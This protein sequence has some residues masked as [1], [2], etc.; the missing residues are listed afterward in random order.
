MPNGIWLAIPGIPLVTAGLIGI[1]QILGVTRTEEGER[2]VRWL[3]LGALVGS[4][5]LVLIAVA[6]YLAHGVPQS[7]VVANWLQS[8]QYVSTLSFSIDGLSLTFATL[9][10]VISLLVMRFAVNYLHR[11]AGF[12]RFFMVLC[13]FTTALQIIALSGSAVLS[14]VGWELAGISSYLLIAYNWASNTATDNATRAFVTNRI[15]DASFLLGIFMGFAWYGSSEWSVLL[16][17]NVHISGLL[18]AIMTLGFMGAA[19]VKSAQFPFSAWIT[20]ALEGPTPSSTI[21]Y[22]SI[23]VHAGIYLLL[24]IHPL[25]QQVPE[26]G[27]LLGF[28]GVLTVIYGG[29]GGL[30]Q[31]DIKTSLVFSTLAQTGLMLLEIAFGWYA[32]A[33]LHLVLHAIW[34]AYQFLYSPSFAQ[35][36]QWQP[37]PAAPHWLQRYPRLY[38]AAL[39]RFWL[40]PLADW[41]FIRPTQALSQEAQVFDGHILD[42]LSGTPSQSTGI[43]S[44]AD[45][46]AIQQGRLRL[47]NQ[48]GV[49]SGLMGKS[50]QALAEYFEGIEQHLLLQQQSGKAKHTLRLIGHYLERVDRLLSQPRYLILLVAVTL[51]VIL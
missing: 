24:R 49:G 42:K 46:Q 2:P 5:I 26:L 43:S 39:H 44:L 35:F 20:R 19:L 27:Y 50:M 6:D 25:L 34:R 16:A 8:G 7:L 1:L 47:E 11:E 48:I 18:L 21:F 13:L 10:A 33:L 23:M 9:I 15:G 41:L 37:A 14:F 32:L 51:V 31:T 28:I 4:L 3:G 36:V 40:D 29:L 38:S 17:P 12:A 30:V 45:M 22:G